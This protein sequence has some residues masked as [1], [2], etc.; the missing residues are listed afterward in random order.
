MQW[1][2]S[3]PLARRANAILLWAQGKPKAEIAR[4][5]QAARPSVNRWIK[6]YLA[7]DLDGLQAD[8][9]GTKVRSPPTF[10]GEQLSVPTGRHFEVLRRI[11]HA[12]RVVHSRGCKCLR[13]VFEFG[14]E[15]TLD[16]IGPS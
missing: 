11:L 14:V 1:N 7:D 12:T 8:L 9:P 16:T 4:R 5:L 13:P 15:K 3:R 2:P 10:I 6:W